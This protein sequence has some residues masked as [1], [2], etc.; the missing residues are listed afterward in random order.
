M[1]SRLVFVSLFLTASASAQPSE[2]SSDDAVRLQAFAMLQEMGTEFDSTTV[3]AMGALAERFEALDR[4]KLSLY[5]AVWNV[6]TDAA[7]LALAHTAVPEAGE[8]YAALVSPDGDV[9]LA[10]FVETQPA[11]PPAMADLVLQQGGNPSAVPT[12]TSYTIRRV[13]GDWEARLIF[14]ITH[15]GSGVEEAKQSAFRQTL[16]STGYSQWLRAEQNPCYWSELA[17]RW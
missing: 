6:A 2:L 17:G 10:L 8:P 16:E 11:D 14:P 4:A 15:V 9:G 12:T 7:A 13:G 5:D 3:D 1:L